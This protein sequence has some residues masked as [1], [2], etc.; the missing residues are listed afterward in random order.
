MSRKQQ[1]TAKPFPWLLKTPRISILWMLRI[2]LRSGIS[3]EFLVSPGF[4]MA[5]DALKLPVTEEGAESRLLWERLR[6]SLERLES[7]T[8]APRMPCALGANLDLLRQSFSFDET[9]CAILALAILLRIDEALFQV[10]DGSRQSINAPEA[11]SKVLG[12]SPTKIAKALEP[13]SRLRRSC[14]IEAS[15]G[16][17]I[18]Q[19]LRLR[20]GG[21]RKLGLRKLKSADEMLDGV[22]VKAPTPALVPEDYAHLK[23]DFQTLVRFIEEALD[24]GR[25]GVNVL[26]YGPPGTGKSELVRALAAQLRTRLLDVADANE[27]GEIRTPQERLAGAVT[28]LFLLGRRKAVVCFDEVEVIFND[29]SKLFGKPSTAES[30]K[31]FFNRLLEHNEVPVFWIANSVHGIDPAFVR[32]FD[33]VVHLESPPR[34][35]RLR[36][37]E[38]ECGSL[39]PN[40]QLRR[41]ARLDYITPALVMRAS[42]VVR[43]VGLRDEKKAETLFETVLDGVLQ[44]QG[45][46]PLALSLG[47]SA[48][49]DFDPGL[50]NASENLDAL[51]AGLS[52]SINGRICLYGPPGT[53]KTA[54]GEWLADRLGKPLIL[55]RVSDL[56]SPFLGVMERNLAGAFAAAKRDDAIL[57]IDEV[58]SFLRDRRQAER[59]WE[60]SQVSEFLTQLERFDGLFVASTNL[61]DN[62]DPAALRRFD[63]KIC[64]DYLR[65]EQAAT[66]LERSLAAW[67]I[68]SASRADEI[69]ISSHRIT[70]GD[71]AVVARKHR[72]L[73]FRDAGKVIDALVAE[74]EVSRRTASRS[75]GFV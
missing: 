34:D 16:G 9:D 40:E 60:V 51:A 12:I 55:K 64:M 45:Y 75:I 71:F 4:A 32:R 14:L 61:M 72:V 66:C 38:R 62:L 15:S 59:P 33:L 68:G 1:F 24:S 28:G 27:D 43:R 70:P 42:S 74:A 39:L 5:R 25:I 20:R 8:R 48:A 18:A 6:A 13:G 49:A 67:G 37:L 26:L 57:Q 36:L 73:P 19:I 69:R 65:P 41:L 2:L 11:L 30:Q 46:D 10:A 29:G 53:G 52:R 7:N 3:R 23:P 35:Q 44:A 56:Q 54:F 58:D 50:C 47:T 22:L 17:G 21:L 31:S 63:Y